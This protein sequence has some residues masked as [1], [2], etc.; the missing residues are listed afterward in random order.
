MGSVYFLFFFFI[1]KKAKEFD[2]RCCH[3]FFFG[4]LV[5]EGNG[6]HQI[7]LLIDRIGRIFHVGFEAELGFPPLFVRDPKVLKAWRMA[8]ICWRLA[9]VECDGGFLFEHSLEWRD[10]IR[11]RS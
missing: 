3:E 9:W 8:E 6:F 5:Y 2:Y 7:C 10:Q 1:F 11:F 4:N